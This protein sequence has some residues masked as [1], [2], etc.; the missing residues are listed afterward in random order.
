M[1][2]RELVRLT[3]FKIKDVWID[4]SYRKQ[5]VLTDNAHGSLPKVERGSFEYLA[6]SEKSSAMIARV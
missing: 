4:Q 5:L 1:R 2:D 3:F 6:S